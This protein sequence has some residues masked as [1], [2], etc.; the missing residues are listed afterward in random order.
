MTSNLTFSNHWE[1]FPCRINDNPFSIRFDTAVANL[2]EETKAK[3]PH[4]LVLQIYA[5]EVNENG[6]PTPAERDRINNI[7]D[8]L[9]GGT[10]DIR[11]MGVITGDGRVRFAFC[12]NGDAEAE[13]IIQT[14]LGDNLDTV[15]FEYGVFPNDNFTY[16]YNALVP[17]IYEQNWIM[18]RHVCTNLEEGGETFQT[19]REIDFFCYFASEQHI[20]DVVEKLK[21]QGFV[22]ANRE[23]TERGDYS[24]HLTLEEIPAF[25]RINEITAD[26]LDLLEGTDGY[27]DGWGSP[28]CK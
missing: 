12:Y 2:D 27:F 9:I 24:L 5:N 7:E 1:Y 19:P 21:L 15:K 3:Y 8:N 28:I 14:L 10:Y 13:N 25:A 11:F 17:N 16:F 4:T 22:E 23:K 26:I 20:Q 18:N 6:F